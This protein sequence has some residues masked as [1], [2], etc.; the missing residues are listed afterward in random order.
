MLETMNVQYTDSI[1]SGKWGVVTNNAYTPL[2]K[3]LSISKQTVPDVKGMGLKDALHLLEN[4]NIKVTVKGK[5]KVTSQ[6]LD[7]GLAINTG[8]TMALELN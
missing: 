7:A 2:L 8:Q 3:G 1:T 5:G 4:M 6:S